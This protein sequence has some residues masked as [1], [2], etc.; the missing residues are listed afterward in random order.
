MLRGPLGKGRHPL[1]SDRATRHLPHKTLSML[2]SSFVQMCVCMSKHVSFL[3]PFFF[4]VGMPVRSRVDHIHTPSLAPT[5]PPL[6]LLLPSVPLMLLST[7]P[8]CA[9]PQ[10]SHH[11]SQNVICN[12]TF[13]TTGSPSITAGGGPGEGA[14]RRGGPRS[15]HTA[16]VHR[17]GL[18]RQQPPDGWGLQLPLH[19]RGRRWW[20]SAQ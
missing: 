19:P 14:A 9:H 13:R 17:D 10:F 2:H 8:S 1:S 20:G 11:D 16:P 7:T 5:F 4:Y 6:L 3:A 18:G 15:A 12:Q